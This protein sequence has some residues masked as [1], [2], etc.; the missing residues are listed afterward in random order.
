MSDSDDESSDSDDEPYV[1]VVPDP[2]NPFYNEMEDFTLDVG[3]VT[4]TMRRTTI[5]EGNS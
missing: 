3:A 1:G 5:N 4:E 2:A